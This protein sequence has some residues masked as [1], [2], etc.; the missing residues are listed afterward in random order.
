MSNFQVALGLGCFVGWAVVV[1]FVGIVVV[2]N[3]AEPAAFWTSSK[4]RIS[5][6]SA[7]HKF[8]AFC[9][10]DNIRAMSEPFMRC[11]SGI[12]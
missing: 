2:V 5:I 6:Q 11:L 7:S 1:G 12:K 3:V 10:L 4:T 9:M 8:E